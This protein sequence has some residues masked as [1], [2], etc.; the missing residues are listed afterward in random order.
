MLARMIALFSYSLKLRASAM[1]AAGRGAALTDSAQL[2]MH[3]PTLATR[4][5]AQLLNRCSLLD[6]TP[7]PTRRVHRW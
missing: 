7:G 3:G 6:R 5:R 2:L 1:P 4:A